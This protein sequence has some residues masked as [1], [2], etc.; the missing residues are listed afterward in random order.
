MEST[1]EGD[2]GA[3]ETVR[4]EGCARRDWGLV[5]SMGRV[6]GGEEWGG[7]GRGLKGGGGDWRGRGGEEGKERQGTQPL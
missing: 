5:R 1:S 2:G 4:A 3:S 6:E 7:E